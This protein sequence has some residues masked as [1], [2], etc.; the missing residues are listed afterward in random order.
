MHKKKM[1]DLFSIQTRHGA[2]ITLR[3]WNKSNVIL[4]P[5]ESAATEC[6]FIRFAAHGADV[7]V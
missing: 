4:T 7:R 1:S 2:S 3:C 5:L 6:G